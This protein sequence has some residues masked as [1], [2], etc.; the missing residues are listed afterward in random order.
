[1][2]GA[3]CAIAPG[4]GLLLRLR[5]LVSSLYQR[6][7]GNAYLLLFLTTF[8]W[9]GNAVASPLAVGH[10]S[11][12]TLVLMRWIIVMVVLAVIARDAIAADWPVLKKHL[13]Y[14]FVMGAC[15]YTAFNTLFYAA[16][17]HTTAIN[18]SILQ[19]AMPVVVMVVGLLAFRERTT[20]LQW[21][22][23]A[24]TMLGVVAV[25]S[26]G[27][28]RRLAALTFNHGDLLIIGATWLYAVYTVALRRRP[29]VSALGFFA[30]MAGAAVATSIPL[31]VYEISSGKALWPTW[32]GWLLILYIGLGPSLLS[33]LMYMRGVQ[34][35]GPIR[36]GIFMNIV[37]VLGP[38]LAVLILGEGFGWHH[39]FGLALVL[40][41]IAISERGRA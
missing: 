20:L 36:A 2:D 21:A 7:S 19:G 29:Q 15:G 1:M 41:G 25:A 12:M 6:L 18:I 35:I 37:P 17:H 32:Q 14:L 5:V 9:A 23:V 24:V 38:I 22:G 31:A 34:L 11:P 40:S 39:A 4:L 13:P 27:D 16:G 3:H 8:F 10:L 26:E 28:V 33:Q 30:F